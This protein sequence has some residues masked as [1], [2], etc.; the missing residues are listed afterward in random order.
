[1]KK[2]TL[3]AVA[4]LLAGSA[5]A[6]VLNGIELSEGKDTANFKYYRVRNMRAM[7]LNYTN[8][9]LKNI[10]GDSINTD[11]GGFYMS[12]T[13]EDGETPTPQ[14]SERP[15]MGLTNMGGNWWLSFA[16][17]DEIKSPYTEFWYFVAGG[18]KNPGTVMIKN[19]V[20]DGNV[21]TQSKTAVDLAGYRRSNMD[22][23]TKK[24]LYFVL[25][26]KPAFEAM[27]TDETSW[28]DSILQNLTAEDFEMAFAFS[29]KDTI[30]DQQDYRNQC[31]DMNNYINIKKHIVKVDEN[32]DTVVDANGNPTY[33]RYG[34]AGVDRTW[35]PVT[36]TSNKNHWE[37]NGSLFFVEPAATADALEAIAQYKQIIAQGF[38]DGAVEAAKIAFAGTVSMIKGWENCPNLFP[39]DALPKLRNIR[40]FCENWNGEG[41]NLDVVCNPDTRDAYIAE[42]E[43]MAQNK[44]N[45]AASLVGTGCIVTF[46]NQTALR[47]LEKFVLEGED[48]DPDLV[49]TNAFLAA[50][51]DFS[52]REGSTVYYSNEQSEFEDYLGQAI[53]PA[54]EGDEY[55]QFELIPGNGADAGKFYLYNA[56]TESY[57][58]KPHDNYK[59]L[60]GE[61]NFLSEASAINEISWLTTSDIADAAPFTFIGCPNADSQGEPSEQELDYMYALDLNTDIEN[62]VRLQ[63]NY[64]VSVFNP[65]IM[66]YEV[67]STEEHYIHRGSMGSDYR[68]IDWRN[69]YNNWFADTNVF[70]VESVAKGS[71]DE[72]AAATKA[73]STGIYDLQG[74]RVSK[75]GKG[76]Y[77]VNGVKSFIR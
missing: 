71:I 9:V 67:V 47:D 13:L 2:F 73:K 34:F 51:G 56:A 15:Y 44:L 22:F 1:M 33:W 37:N 69:T 16:N 7:R 53:V 62:K 42:V 23:N 40:K 70:F 39:D 74:R 61:D 17:D 5:S 14:I 63:S 11:R 31:L 46:Q 49:P 10:D 48:M 57:V 26:A 72:V 50:G 64:E 30:S 55:A 66:D 54:F 45:E 60:G 38:K 77:I 65:A 43:K 28:T 8:G 3:L 21:S 35:S 12:S 4:A 20:I 58:R 41:V 52:Y 32:G 36:T 27:N 24:N 75:A 76:V 68:F 59:H 6:E 29:L 18:S 19:A 25:P